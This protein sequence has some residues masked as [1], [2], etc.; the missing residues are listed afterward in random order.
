MSYTQLRLRRVYSDQGPVELFCL[1]RR[2][3]ALGEDLD[4]GWPGDNVRVSSHGVVGAQHDVNLARG[5]GRDGQA[6]GEREIIS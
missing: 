2:S 3:A 1:R 5:A 6:R 4:D